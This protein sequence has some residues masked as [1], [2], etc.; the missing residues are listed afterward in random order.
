MLMPVP[1]PTIICEWMSTVHSKRKEASEMEQQTAGAR[2]EAH[3]LRRRFSSN[4]R[5][6]NGLS[7]YMKKPVNGME[8][9]MRHCLDVAFEPS[10]M[11]SVD[12]VVK[13]FWNAKAAMVRLRAVSF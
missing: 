9:L 13:Y 3:A 5:V 1:Q 6:V 4:E 11:T 7:L 8:D 2:K 10:E 12:D